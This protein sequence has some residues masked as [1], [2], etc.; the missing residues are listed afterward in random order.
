MFLPLGVVG[1]DGGFGRF[2]VSGGSD[3]LFDG[4]WLVHVGVEAVIFDEVLA[5]Q[6]NSLKVTGL[7]S[8][9]M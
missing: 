9:V 8:W 3:G 1:L 4:V 6:L 5:E 2:C 7:R